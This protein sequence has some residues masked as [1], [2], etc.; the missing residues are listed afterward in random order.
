MS[1][2]LTQFFVVFKVSTFRAQIA[3]KRLFENLHVQRR[4]IIYYYLR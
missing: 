4:I 3:N 2:G 1:Y